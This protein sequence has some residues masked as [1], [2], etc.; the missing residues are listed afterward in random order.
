MVQLCTAPLALSKR[1]ISSTYV[2]THHIFS[3]DLSDAQ[4][5]LGPPMSKSKMKNDQ[6]W[7]EELKQ[8]WVAWVVLESECLGC[9]WQLKASLKTS[10]IYGL[11][12]QRK[13]SQS[14]KPRSMHSLTP[15][16]ACVCVCVWVRARA[17]KVNIFC[18]HVILSLWSLSNRACLKISRK[19]TVS[20]LM[21]S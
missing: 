3:Q 10:K 8:F 11:S 21:I 6:D 13:R 2:Q 5:W 19:Y 15:M 20:K 1:C 16:R 4:T 9:N 12:V 18:M 7:K 14:L 17:Q